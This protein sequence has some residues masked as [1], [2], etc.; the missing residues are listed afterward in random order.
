MKNRKNHETLDFEKN[1]EAH[2]IYLSFLTLFK[3]MKFESLENLNIFCYG[4]TF[5]DE[6]DFDVNNENISEFIFKFKDVMKKISKSPFQME[7]L[8]KF[9]DEILKVLS[10]MEE[11][12]PMEFFED[13]RNILKEELNECKIYFKI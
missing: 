6:K 4:L 10:M 8:L 13:K 2:L 3:E 5:S 7:T 11:I 9:N 12:F 1:E